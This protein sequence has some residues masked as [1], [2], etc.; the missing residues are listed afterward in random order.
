MSFFTI[1]YVLFAIERRASIKDTNPELPFV[2]VTKILGS[3]W[4]AMTTGERQVISYNDIKNLAAKADQ[5]TFYT[6]GVTCAI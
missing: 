3:E 5:S 6:T 2:E 4:S 1:R